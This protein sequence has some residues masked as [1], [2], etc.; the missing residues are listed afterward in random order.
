MKEKVKL[1][2]FIGG[3]SKCTPGVAKAHGPGEVQSGDA[4]SRTPQACQATVN[5]A[6]LRS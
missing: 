3:D 2:L 5:K 1:C 4:R 6:R